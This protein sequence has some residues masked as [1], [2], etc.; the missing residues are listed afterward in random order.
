MAL[1]N[2]NPAHDK[3]KVEFSRR[4][5]DKMAANSGVEYDLDSGT[6]KISFLGRDYQVSHPDGNVVSV[7]GENVP[8]ENKVCILH[9]LTKASGLGL[10][11]KQISFS[12]LPSGFIYVTP[13]T[14]RC[15]RP[16]VSIF[17]SDP[18]KL[19]KAGEMLG[20]TREDLGDYAVTVPVFPKIPVTFV[21]WEGDDEFPPSG[22][23]VFDAS[24]PE[25][26]ETEDYALL[27]GLAVFTMK[28]L[29]GQ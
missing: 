11:G 3:A 4:V 25:H 13:F 15:I 6:F 12:E 16:L 28:R 17:G 22:S 14:N 23:I 2:L 21:L 24:A 29:A 10:T 18:Q 5:P 19:I 1:V 8:L 20:G 26:L 9:Y 7:D 27:P